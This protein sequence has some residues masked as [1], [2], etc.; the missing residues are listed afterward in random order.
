MKVLT[1]K[2]SGAAL[3]KMGVAATALGARSRR[4]YPGGYVW[5]SS[6]SY[7]RNGFGTSNGRPSRQYPNGMRGIMLIL[8]RAAVDRTEREI[9]ELLR[10]RGWEEGE[11]R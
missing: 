7:E 9:L 6:R 1:I 10:Q 5:R 3:A 2:V 8:V 11:E 4:L